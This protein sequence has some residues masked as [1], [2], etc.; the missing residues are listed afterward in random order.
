MWR[1]EREKASAANEGHAPTRPGRTDGGEKRGAYALSALCS[2]TA[3]CA[4]LLQLL[5][6]VKLFL[7]PTTRKGGRGFYKAPST[8]TSS[9][10]RPE[11]EL[12]LSCGSGGYY[13]QWSRRRAVSCSGPSS[14][15]KH[16]RRHPPTGISWASTG[17]YC[18]C[19]RNF[20][21]NPLQ[22]SKRKS[23]V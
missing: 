8:A 17:V 23:T 3:H 9:F 21:G 2:T 11:G 10:A 1:E 15:H 12:G 16:T 13:L 22:T 14:T 4:V 18:S 7:T 6:G 5:S 19:Y 20:R